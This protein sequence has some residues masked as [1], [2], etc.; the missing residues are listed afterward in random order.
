MIITIDGFIATGKSTIAKELAR[1]IGYIFFDTGAMYRCLTYALLKNK[2]NIDDAAA[3][4]K[5]LDNFKFDYKIRRGERCYFV[6]DEDVSLKIRGPAVT[7]LVSKVS[8]IPA[9][10]KKLISMQQ[11]LAVGVNAV[12][13]GRDMG[14][15]VFPNAQL[16]LFLTGKPEVR[17]ARRFAELRTKFPE[18]TTMLTM[19]Q[20]IEDINARDAYDSKRELSP[21]KE[22]PDALVLDTSNLTIDEVILK[23]LEFKDSMKTRQLPAH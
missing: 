18:D 20:V 19:A 23:I 4:A 16:K 17:A 3:L 15:V 2:I 8:A 9:V 10:R 1:R 7:S 13:E 22:A 11:D 21:L 6:D 14:T 12:F 5:C